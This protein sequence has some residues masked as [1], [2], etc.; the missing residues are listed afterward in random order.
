MNQQKQQQTGAEH[1]SSVYTIG[2]AYTYTNAVTQD[3]QGTVDPNNSTGYYTPITA[4]LG[5]SPIPSGTQLVGETHS[6]PNDLGFS[7][8][9]IER[10]QLL[11]LPVYGLRFFRVHTW[12]SRMALLSSGTRLHNSESILAQESRNDS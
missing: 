6:H 3:K 4:P 8:K 9:D 5:K 1:A 12:V 7:S 11:T 10:T 2:P